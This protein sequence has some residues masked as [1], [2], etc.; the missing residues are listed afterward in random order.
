MRTKETEPYVIE[1]LTI[2]LCDE[3][4]SAVTEVM[5]RG[6]PV[7]VQFDYE[8]GSKDDDVEPQIY[9]LEVVS[10]AGCSLAG[11][12]ISVTPW[13]GCD[14]T[15]FLTRSQFNAIEGAMYD[16][17]SERAKEASDQSRIDT[18]EQQRQE[19]AWAF[20]DARSLLR[21]QK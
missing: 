6:L 8:H 12:R 14:L 16:R 20:G 9:G 4:R 5:A 15:G 1:Q 10:P 3:N 19:R 2:Q 7:L 18:A 11:E 21:G 17:M 13:G